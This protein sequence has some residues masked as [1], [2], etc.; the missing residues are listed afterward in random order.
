MLIFAW[1]RALDSQRQQPHPCRY[2]LAGR[3]APL[4]WASRRREL[5]LEKAVSCGGDGDGGATKGT[6]TAEPSW[7]F[8]GNLNNFQTLN[9]GPAVL[10]VGLSP[11]A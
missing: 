7:Y 2:T 8:Y 6:I 11:P 10:V 1:F 5:A 3:F 9:S 4:A